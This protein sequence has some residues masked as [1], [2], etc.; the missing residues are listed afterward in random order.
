M[1]NCV[2]AIVVRHINLGAVPD[3]GPDALQVHRSSIPALPVLPLLHMAMMRG[4]M[5]RNVD[6]RV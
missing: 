5:R 6:V 3:K 2:L 1:V 4:Y